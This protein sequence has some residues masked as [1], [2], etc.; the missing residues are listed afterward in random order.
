MIL[1]SQ[2]RKV[3]KE[4]RKDLSVTLRLCE[5][6][7]LI[8]DIIKKFHSILNKISLSIVLYT[9]LVIHFNFLK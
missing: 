1:I 6:E 9:V 7:I 4:L 8:T 2:R 3:R 5:R